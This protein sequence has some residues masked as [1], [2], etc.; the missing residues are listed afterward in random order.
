M[1][2]G[3]IAETMQDLRG[4]PLSGDMIQFPPFLI[5]HMY[6][7]AQEEMH[8]WFVLYR[9]NQRLHGLLLLFLKFFFLTS[10]EKQ[11]CKSAFVMICTLSLHVST[12]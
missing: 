9:R 7:V 3:S 5:S 11:V 12:K 4:S 8:E 6:P 2:T 1:A 10:V